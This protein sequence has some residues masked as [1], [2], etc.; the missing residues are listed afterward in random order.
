MVPFVAQSNLKNYA[1]K[2]FGV[3]WNLDAWFS[4]TAQ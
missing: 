4:P 2:R 1:P 3:Q